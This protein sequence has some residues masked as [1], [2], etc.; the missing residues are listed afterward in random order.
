MPET[1][2]GGGTMDRVEEGKT[3]AHHENPRKVKGTRRKGVTQFIDFRTG[4]Q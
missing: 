4:S 3:L 2:H 1:G